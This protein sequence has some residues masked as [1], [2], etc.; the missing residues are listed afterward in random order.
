MPKVQTIK[1]ELYLRSHLLCPN[2]GNN[3]TGNALKSK[4]GH[5]HHYYHCNHC[6]KVRFRADNA[7]ERLLS[8]IAEIK[9]SKNAN[10]S[11]HPD[12]EKNISGKET[13]KKE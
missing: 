6:Y 7:H 1:E 9:F 10:E 8:I 5:K 12:G 4:T 13:K 11:L 2:C 3:M